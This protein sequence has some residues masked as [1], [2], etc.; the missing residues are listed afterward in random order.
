MSGDLE[1]QAQPA[2]LWQVRFL[3]MQES[4]QAF[5][6]LQTLQQCAPPPPQEVAPS[7]PA[8]TSN[9]RTSHSARKRR[10]ISLIAWSYGGDP[11]ALR[12]VTYQKTP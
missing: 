9:A 1:S 4:P 2:P 11:S 7:P 8:D 5:P 10:R 6:V 12:T 3:A